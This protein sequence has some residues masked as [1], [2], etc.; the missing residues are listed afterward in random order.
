VSDYTKVFTAAGTVAHVLGPLTSPNSTDNAVCGRSSWPDY[1]H[2]TGSQDEIER[3]QDLALCVR[4][5]AVLAQRNSG[6]VTR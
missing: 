3:A 2:G 4:C 1:W 5:T 6:I